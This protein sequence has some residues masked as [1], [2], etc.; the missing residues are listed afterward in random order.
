MRIKCTVALAAVVIL[1]AICIQPPSSAVQGAHGPTA[2]ARREVIDMEGRK[3]ILPAQI[4]RIVTIGP[5]PVINSYVFVF[6]DGDKIINGL[7]LNFSFSRYQFELRIVPSLAS[8]PSIEGGGTGGSIPNVEQLLALAP[9]VVFGA[10]RK[11][12][13]MLANSG[14]AAVCLTRRKPDDIKPM[15]RLMGQILNKPEI[16]EEYA[17]YYDQTVKRVS[18]IAEQIPRGQRLRVLFCSLKSGN[19]VYRIVDWWIETAGGISLT[20]DGSETEHRSFT[21]EQIMAWNPDVLFVSGTNEIAEFKSDPL[22]QK[23]KAVQNHR[24]YAVPVG[25]HFWGQN[26]SENPLSLLWAAKKMYPERF[27]DVDM[28]K[29]MQRF[30]GEFFHYKMA[31]EEAREILAA[32]P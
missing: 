23:L 8:K 31:P 18:T 29:E 13:E 3:V 15:L 7:P 25:A 6:G 32:Q 2:A 22:F 11:T 20:D 12:A 30:Y 9:D 14:I 10:N 19:M 26:T 17:R 27:K 28:V 4:N 1:P 21:K 16:A 24:I 5:V